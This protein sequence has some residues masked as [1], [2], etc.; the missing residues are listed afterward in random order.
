[1]TNYMLF[2]TNTV[3][4]LICL[5]SVR[6]RSILE[7]LDTDRG[8]SFEI[9]DKWSIRSE[10]F[11]AKGGATQFFS[12]SESVFTELTTGVALVVSICPRFLVGKLIKS[13]V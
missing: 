1:M 12:T 13:L 6:S 11:E 7:M 4:C 8:T 9:T 2:L 5:V 10:P 3:N